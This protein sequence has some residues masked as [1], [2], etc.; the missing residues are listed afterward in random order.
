MKKYNVTVN[1]TKYE[2]EIEEVGGSANKPASTSSG[3]SSAPRASA[4][5]SSSA[6]SAPVSTGSSSTKSPMPGSILDIRVKVGDTVEP[7]TVVLILEAMKMQNEITAG[8]AGRVKGIYVKAGEKVV[9]SQALFEI[10]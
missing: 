6:S 9:L 8:K 1:G 4:L 10:E 7:N 2:V 3:S 5:A